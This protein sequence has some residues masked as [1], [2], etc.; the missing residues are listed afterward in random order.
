MLIFQ[1]NLGYLV[2]LNFSFTCVGRK[3]CGTTGTGFMSLN[4]QRQSTEESQSTD[5]PV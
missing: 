1:V 4:Q 3:P 2:Y 5:Y